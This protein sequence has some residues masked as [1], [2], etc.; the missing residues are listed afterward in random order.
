MPA[1]DV[2]KADVI[3]GVVTV[4]ETPGFPILTFIV[5]V[6][7]LICLANVTFN[8]VDAA[9]I[10]RRRLCFNPTHSP[11]IYL[12][13]PILDSVFEAWT[14]IESVFK[15]FISYNIWDEKYRQHVMLL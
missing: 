5:G 6:E 7:S 12:H 4:M 14:I 13:F 15:C 3:L 10:I 2:G 1:Y 9:F 8:V 11:N